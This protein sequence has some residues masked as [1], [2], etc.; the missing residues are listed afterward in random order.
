MGPCI[1]RPVQKSTLNTQCAADIILHIIE[2]IENAKYSNIDENDI[3]HIKNVIQKNLSLYNPVSL[4]NDETSDDP[5]LMRLLGITTDT[6]PYTKPRTS[7][8]C[9]SI[10]VQFKDTL[11]SNEFDVYEFDK[12]TQGNPLCTLGLYV[13][14]KKG[15]IE[16][17]S[18]DIQKLVLFLG[19]IESGYKTKNLYHNNLHATNVLQLLFF[20]MQERPICDSILLL[21]VYVAAIVHDFK[22]M[23]K[24]NEFLIATSHFIANTY[25][26]IAPL[27]N[28]HVSEAMKLLQYDHFN[29]IPE[30]YFKSF[31]QQVINLVLSTNMTQ[32][33]S[34]CNSH[35]NTVFHYLQLALKAADIG[36]ICF[37]LKHHLL[38][39][40]NLEE[41]FFCQGDIEKEMGMQVTPLFDRND[42][43]ITSTQVQFLEMVARPLF[44]KVSKIFPKSGF[45]LTETLT[46]N[47][48]YWRQYNIHSS[49]KEQ[50]SSCSLVRLPSELV[51]LSLPS[52]TLEDYEQKM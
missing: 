16:S 3:K 32:H 40:Q 41:E 21:S 9:K 7:L 11:L 30:K 14:Q 27:E 37:P 34:I 33:F 22:H 38:W 23:G 51:F 31:R 13:I 52:M 18:L 1:S 28:W 12:A 5:Y 47:L 39:V 10:P 35:E 48:K 24:T 15:L 25:N 8:E 45:I 49:T 29:F 17:L 20:I 50:Y 36:H 6:I 26:D 19:K 46:K 4:Q 43:G 42:F 2:Q 44:L